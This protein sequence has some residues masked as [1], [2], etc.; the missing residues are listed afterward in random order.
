MDGIDYWVL[1]AIR[2]VQPRVI[3]VEY[4]SGWLADEARTIPDIK[5]FQYS[6]RK[7]AFCSASLAAYCNLLGRRGYRLVGCNRNRL[8][9]FF[10]RHG[11]GDDVLPEVS[12]ASCLDHP[13][14][15]H[16]RRAYRHHILAQTDWIHV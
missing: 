15:T 9:A 1:N 3:V 11:L 12:V 7:L 8:N 4:H 6:P 13:K 16:F 2:C 5:G 10:V 14:L